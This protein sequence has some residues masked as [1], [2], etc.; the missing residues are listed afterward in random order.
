M[1]LTYLQWPPD[2]VGR[3]DAIGI[4]D[5]TITPVSSGQYAQTSDFANETYITDYAPIKFQG[6]V[7][8]DAAP[9]DDYRLLTA[10]IAAM[11]G[12]VNPIELPIPDRI[13]P[14]PL[15][16]RNSDGSLGADVTQAQIDQFTNFRSPRVV[17]SPGFGRFARFLYQTG[18]ADPNIYRTKPGAFFNLGQR[19]CQI[20]RS[21]TNQVRY[22][23]TLTVASDKLASLLTL[24]SPDSLNRRRRLLRFIGPKVM[25]RMRPGYTPDLST[26][27]DY[28]LPI[29]IQ[30][31]EAT[32]SDT[33]ESEWRS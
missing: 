15:Q 7:T 33:E 27:A 23:P 4:A 28:S 5:M 25:V 6:T 24:Q 11:Q 12:S 30:W 31:E 10:M 18:N 8:F 1:A 20:T 16:V 9:G 32:D 13:A 21:S 26:N 19:L 2:A 22:V 17:A 3:P 14:V 29:T